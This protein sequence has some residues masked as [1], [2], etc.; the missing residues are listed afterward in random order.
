MRSHV[1]NGISLVVISASWL[2][3][4]AMRRALPESTHKKGKM[5]QF[6]ICKLERTIGSVQRRESCTRGSDLV[7][8]KVRV[9]FRQ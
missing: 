8:V 6:P 7:R 9:Q 5:H 1:L 3:L 4:N 2:V